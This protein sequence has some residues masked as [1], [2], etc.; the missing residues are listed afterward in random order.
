LDFSRLRT[1]EIVAGI[2]GLALLLFMFFDWFGGGVEISAGGTEDVPGLGEVPTEP[3]VE[4]TGLSAWDSLQ[5]FSG[6]LI[7]LTAV[8]AVALAALAAAGKRIRLGG[9]PRGEVTATLG[10]LAVALILWRML[11]NPGDL[12]IGIF[13]GLIAAAAIAAGALMALRED[14]FEPLVAKA[15]GRTR[16][17]T[18]TSRAASS[19]SSA[20][21]TTKRS[22]ARKPAAKSRA[23]SS[24]SK[25]RSSSSRARKS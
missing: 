22:A 1:G 4:E 14:G 11:A 24:S 16:A 18:T 10:A 5:D 8:S 7:A 13:L 25:S 6:F 15:G 23:K 17:A 2:G 19:R 21:A 3:K 20:S 12:K 9:L